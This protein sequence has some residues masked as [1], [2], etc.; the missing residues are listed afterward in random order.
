[1]PKHLAYITT[2]I[3]YKELSIKML[4]DMLDEYDRNYEVDN[5]CEYTG[6]YNVL[7]GCLTIATNQ[8]IKEIEAENQKKI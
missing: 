7:S 6:M 1:M 5:E 3:E 2:I 4:K 8:K